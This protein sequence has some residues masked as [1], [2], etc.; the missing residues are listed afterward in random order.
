MVE[1]KK[2]TA[3]KKTV[4]KRTTVKKSVAQK[5]ASPAKKT[6]SSR[7]RAKKKVLVTGATG[8]IG[9]RLIPVLLDKGF[10]VRVLV[11]NPAKIRDRIWA[12]KVE[13]VVGDA[14]D[15]RAVDEALHGISIAYYLLHSLSPDPSF[16]LEEQKIATIFA[17]SAKKNKV[18]RII[19]LGGL[20]D[21]NEEDLSPHLRSR[22]KVGE[23]LHDSGVPT[24]EFRAAVII[25]SGSASFEM[26]RYLAE[27]L[28]AMT[29]PKWVRTRIQPIA[30]RDVLYYLVEAA[31]IPGV[32]N[33]KFDI[34]G[35]D[36]LT[37]E[38]MMRRYAKNAGL[39]KRLIIPVPVL[40]PGLSSH[41]V[42]L[43]TPVPASIAR[44]LVESLKHEV[45]CHEQDINNYIKEPQ[46][47]LIS[48]DEAC[49]KALTRIREANVKTSWV[50]RTVP[51][52]PSEPYPG[53]PQ[54]TGGS[55]YIERQD[56]LIDAPVEKV[57]K[58]LESIGGK[59]GWYSW[60]LAWRVR[61]GV[62]RLVGGVGLRRG[63]RNPDKLQVG[64]AVDFWRVEECK[65]NSLLRLRAE[66]K[67]PGLA[68][69]EFSLTPVTSEKTVLVQRA[70]FHPIGLTG[71]AYWAAVK[72]FHL[73]VFRPMIKKIAQKAEQ[74]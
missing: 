13:V 46:E 55:L 27:R 38:D 32:V 22:G 14:G 11:R 5:K 35:P 9:G 4:A 49:E 68:W 19:Y 57:W 40:S 17:G 34:G 31:T 48:F 45:V 50:E 60:K 61:G 23:I 39:G 74:K 30:V 12:D 41:W 16:E 56:R 63:R 67:V 44:P 69:L 64:D 53:D 66:M 7:P 59:N 54:W 36:I 62:D 15:V 10:H 37:Y 58:I 33:R 52:A 47:G 18:S 29:T 26:L 2:S 1:S 71:H 8:Y 51:G 70:L 73:F 28:P 25:G 43:I 3:A 6:A 72:P 21:P 20:L 65:E 42:G 24:I